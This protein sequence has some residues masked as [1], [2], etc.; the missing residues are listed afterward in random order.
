MLLGAIPTL[1]PLMILTIGLVVA[2]TAIYEL[3]MFFSSRPPSGLR[4]IPGPKGYPLIGNMGQLSIRPQRELSQ[5]ASEYGELF[6]LRLGLTSWVYVNSV[7]ATRDIFDK[8]S[9]YTASRLPRP[10]AN[11]II[12]GDMRF[13]LMA[14]NAKWSFL[15][16]TTH[17]LLTPSKSMAYLNYQELEAKQLAYDL[18]VDNVNQTKFYDHV[19]RYTTSVIMTTTYGWRLPSTVS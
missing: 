1:G 14:D 5:W 9:R 12:G 8:Q 15:R 19:R 4:R 18:L 3:F 2:F 6:Q 13:V 17:R 11:D 10:V 16:S 7:S